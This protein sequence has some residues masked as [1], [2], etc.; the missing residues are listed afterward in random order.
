MKSFYFSV[1][2]ALSFLM[3]MPIQA[4]QDKSLLIHFKDNTTKEIP[5]S[6][7]DSISFDKE[8]AVPHFDISIDDVHPLYVEFTVS[9]LLDRETTYNI[10]IVDKFNFDKYENDEAVVADDLKF[11]QELADGY[12]V[13]LSEIIKQFLI[14]GD[15]NDFHVG[16][17]PDTEYV[18]WAYGLNADGT[19]TT[20]LQKVMFKTGKASHIDNKIAINVRRTASSIEAT[21]TPD[22][23]QLHYTAGLMSSKDALAEGLVPRKMQQALSNQIAD[24]VLGGEPLTMYLDERTERGEGNAIFNGVDPAGKY[25]ISAAYLDNECCLCSEVTI[26]TST[27][28]GVK[29]V[30]STKSFIQDNTTVKRQLSGKFQV[31]DQVRRLTK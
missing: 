31:M 2:M 15:F 6:Q 9:P 10:M 8:E 19:Q 3:A 30:P 16:L 21:Y 4:Q 13:S 26:V 29:S 20:P 7:I 22:D 11:F 28:D 14:T 27:P 12:E 23:N 25:F 24:Y 17:L 1:L 5:V 18:M